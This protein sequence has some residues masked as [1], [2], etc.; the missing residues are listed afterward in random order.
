[1]MEGSKGEVHAGGR[2]DDGRNVMRKLGTGVLAGIVG[3]G[4]T[5]VAQAG[6]FEYEDEA[7]FLADLADMGYAPLVEDFEGPDW[8]HVRSSYPIINSAPSVTSKGITW[9]GNEEISTNQNWG[10]NG[11]WGIFTIYVPPVPTP[12]ELFGD[13]ERTL[14]AVGGW[15]N[16]NPDFGADIAIEIGG[17]VVAQRT[18]GTGHQFLGVI[19][20]EGFMYFHIVDL[21]QEAVWGADDFTFAVMPCPGDLTGD[22]VVDV[23]DLLELLA[24]WGD[25]PGC[26]ADLN[27]DDVVNVFDLLELLGAWGEC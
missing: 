14:Y 3:L 5:S 18:I 12:D 7:L 9:T 27:G 10:R 4:A 11:T 15:F 22:S 8:D 16:S 19:V 13:S 1:M 2:D 20:T 23:F 24:A 17:Q 6:V 21:D 26:D 25:C